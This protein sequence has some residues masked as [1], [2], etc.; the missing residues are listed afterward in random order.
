M[1]SGRLATGKHQ[2]FSPPHLHYNQPRGFP[3]FTSAPE[4]SSAHL[5]L[6]SEFSPEEEESNPQFQAHQDAWMIKIVS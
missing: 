5:T 1:H 6:E 4:E 3:T 2:T